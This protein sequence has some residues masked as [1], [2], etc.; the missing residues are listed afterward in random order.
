M[1][2]AKTLNAIDQYLI[3]QDV[4]HYLVLYPMIYNTTT[5]K[6]IYI[7]WKVTAFLF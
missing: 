2:I 7:I 1:I 6:T 4:I 3:N 5:G